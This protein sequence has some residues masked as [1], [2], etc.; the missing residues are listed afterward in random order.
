MVSG[1]PVSFYN[2]FIMTSQS[3]HSLFL[4]CDLTNLM[5][6]YCQQWERF[7]ELIINF[8]QSSNLFKVMTDPFLKSRRILSFS[9]FFS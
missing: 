4:S 2:H 6:E 1:N 8:L 3:Y 7:G 9:T 5:R